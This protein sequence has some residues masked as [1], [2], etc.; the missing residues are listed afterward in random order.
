MEVG[1]RPLHDL[2]GH[3]SLDRLIGILGQADIHFTELGHLGDVGVVGLLGVLGLDLDRLLDRLGADQLLESTGRILERLLGLVGDL[4]G[5]GLEALVHLAERT[6]GRIEAVFTYLLELFETFEHVSPLSRPG[7]CAIAA[8][9]RGYICVAQKTST[10][11]FC[12]AQ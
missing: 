3:D 4:C 10:Q 1:S 6:Y 11:I 5:D 9:A 7:F 8:N 12:T 2:L